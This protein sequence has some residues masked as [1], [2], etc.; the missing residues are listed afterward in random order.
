MKEE[1]DCAASPEK[2]VIWV[3]KLNCLNNILQTSEKNCIREQRMS[4]TELLNKKQQVNFHRIWVM[5]ISPEVMLHC[6]ISHNGNKTHTAM[7]IP[8][9]SIS[10]KFQ[11]TKS[12][13]KL[14]HTVFL[15]AHVNS[16]EWAQKSP[17]EAWGAVMFYP[18]SH[19]EQET[20]DRNDWGWILTLEHT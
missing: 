17:K 8:C 12:K 3:S 5:W 15:I 19:Q 6:C 16:A 1:S 2:M 9:R 13:A 20:D 11:V 18:L 7:K 4:H 14:C 10:G